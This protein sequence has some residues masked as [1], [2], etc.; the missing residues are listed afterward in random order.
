VAGLNLLVVV[1]REVCMGSGLCSIYAAA[2]FVI[3][4]EA[5]AVPI[6]P[7]GDGLDA[8]RIAV[9]ACPTGAIRL[10]TDESQEG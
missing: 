4:D 8:I 7:P 1:D 6:E 10:I 3:D 5:K 9:S 2:S